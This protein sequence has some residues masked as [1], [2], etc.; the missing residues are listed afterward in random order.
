M[1]EHDLI[2][3]FDIELNSKLHWLMSFGSGLWTPDGT[4]KLDYDVFLEILF[5]K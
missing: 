4:G 5:W 3:G 2:V 1:P